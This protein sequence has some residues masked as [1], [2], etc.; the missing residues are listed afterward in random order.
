MSSREW[1]ALRP[2]EVSQWITFERG[3]ADWGY[4]SAN[5]TSMAAKQA[6]G[7]AGLWNRLAQY[8]LA[9]LADEVGMGK[10]MQALGVMALLWKQNPD[11]KV[12]V[13][14]PNRDICTHWIREYRGFLREHYKE[15]DH[16]VRNLADG[17]PVHEP[18]LCKRLPDLQE[19]VSSGTGHFYL[20]T[21]HALSGLLPSDLKDSDDKQ[22][23][24]ERTAREINREILRALDGAGF[25]LIIID[26]A[27][28]F[29]KAGGGSQR[30]GAARG[31][32]GSGN[33]RL[34]KRAL[35]LTA[36]PSHSSLAD[37]PA[38]FSYFTDFERDVDQQDA[39]ELLRKHAVRRLRM[40]EGAADDSGQRR[41]HNKYSYRH[42]RA[43]PADFGDDLNAE[44]FFALYQKKL[45][46]DAAV[47][48]NNRRFMYGYLEGFESVGV[49]DPTDNQDS[50]NNDDQVAADSY[51]TAP[52]TQVL[53]ALT[54]EYH[55]RFSKYP[56]HPKYDKLLQQCV[57]QELFSAGP[58]LHEYKHL[59]FVRRIPSVREITQRVNEAYDELLAKKIV[60]ARGLPK[61]ATVLKDW[62]A[63][64]WSRRFFSD[65]VAPSDRLT[66]EERAQ[67]SA[68]DEDIF[69]QKVTD[70]EK[71]S[72]RIADLF[73]VKSGRLARTDAANV[74][75]RFRKPESL[76]SLF[77][78][79]ASDY[80]NGRY[81]TFQRKKVGKRER[82]SF[83]DAALATRLQ[84]HGRLT[85]D[86]E[87]GHVAGS[88]QQTYQSPLPTAWGLM[89]ELLP[90]ADQALLAR[91]RAQ[92]PGILENLG[93][94]LKAGFLYA[95]P[96]MVELYCW[97]T[98]F[99]PKNNSSNV[100]V[101]Y[102]AFIKLAKRELPNSLMFQYFVSAIRTFE[103]LCEKITD[104]RFADWE[105]PWSELT[106]LQNPAWFASGETSNRQRLILGF[107]SPFYP[108]VLVATSV[109]QE[110][111]NLHLQCRKVHHY[112][113]AW[114]PG[115][116]EQR[117]GRVDRLFG[118]V[119]HRLQQQENTELAIHYPYL[120][121]SFD[122]EQVAS[123]IRMKHDVEGKMDACRHHD[124][125]RQID[126]ANAVE[127]WEDFLRRPDQ[128]NTFADPYPA[129]L[130]PAQCPAFDYLP[131]Q[132]AST[133][134]LTNYLR[135]HLH[136]ISRLHEHDFYRLERSEQHP[137]AQFLLEATLPQSQR[138]QPIVAE[139]RYSSELSALVS[140]TVYYLSLISPLATR[141]ALNANHQEGLARAARRFKAQ[142]E[143]FPLVK[144]ALDK[145][146]A[147]SH[148]YL[149]ARADLP[150]FALDDGH[151][152]LSRQEIEQAYHQ[153]F[154]F[155]DRMEIRLF[156]HEQ[157]LHK[158][159][160][161]LALS[162]DEKVLPAVED[163]FMPTV[164]LRRGWCRQQTPF[165]ATGLKE[166]YLT[167]S[168]FHAIRALRFEG[169]ESVP[170]NLAV[171]SLNNSVP[172]LQFYPRGNHVVVQLAFP[173]GDI[174][175]SEQKLLI[176]WMEHV[177]NN[178]VTQST[179][180]VLEPA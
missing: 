133:E 149:T 53:Q 67:L 140:G 148:F 66:A 94:Y 20:T 107:N 126:L 44:L 58:D 43:L 6:E 137:A 15:V 18:Q 75:L 134:E 162:E 39:P 19:A 70:E 1:G 37:V 120:N 42:E 33:K 86:S 155:A 54:R 30:V 62:R 139:L 156:A 165:G 2:E 31:F 9:L 64:G 154:E 51:T 160:L 117:V 97:F 14:A 85:S 124:T 111:V 7:V 121:R 151:K 46:E 176:R 55:R 108:N 87:A 153:L 175:E 49:T 56:A 103:S 143:E 69:E 28:Y 168:D 159:D 78:E 102:R 34:A 74:R 104:H 141:A 41:F 112:G 150:L 174:Q 158:D 127:G 119:N 4:E 179:D 59:I 170:D 81:N 80:L 116:N 23:L 13:M 8:D 163:E 101:R 171:L 93:N 65:V 96:V 105:K 48:G 130:D 16:L 98:Q 5:K 100:Q 89:F 3:N 76:F 138:R 61:P 27:H 38:I 128:G 167:R 57:P 109:F 122:Q 91:W 77:M 36:T 172:L 29:R 79:P 99:D 50:E 45:V 92:D 12:L 136:E 110:G 17:G 166:E 161:E 123:F 125:D 180:G 135:G 146:K 132:S 52:D 11:A 32:F 60:K 22:R 145:D 68:D 82:D 40:M 114:T 178:R 84:S 115:D 26:E 147:N 83:S 113:I 164:R 73:V 25:D 142:R 131:V 35:L 152:M 21:I 47:S 90:A 106:S 24:A 169:R 129:H 177:S 144:L 63:S 157:D 173:H 72:S 10:T 88:G 118:C 71:L 95:S